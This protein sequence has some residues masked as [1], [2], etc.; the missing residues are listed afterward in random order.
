MA[1]GG[2]L[3]YSIRVSDQRMSFSA[4]HFVIT[5]EYFEN[6]HGHNYTLEVII[7]GPLD[8][9]VVIPERLCRVILRCLEKNREG[10]YQSTEEVRFE[11]AGIEKDM[12]ASV[13]VTT[14]RI[15][16]TSKEITVTFRKRWLLIPI[17]CV[18]LVVAVLGILFLKKGKPVTPSLRQNMLVVLP[19]ENLGLPE[20]EYFADGITEEI[21]SRLATLHEL[22][23]I[24][25]SSAISMARF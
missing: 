7:E 10:R 5:D 21:T 14:E 3:L 12:P 11:I 19:F 9:P 24:S 1:H 13:R 15:P 18:V 25:R 17:L 22:G 6:L 4:S 2:Q 23:V 16:S 20:D 8:V